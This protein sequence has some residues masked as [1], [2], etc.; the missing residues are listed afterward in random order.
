MPTRLINK[1]LTAVSSAFITATVLLV[2]MEANAAPM[3]KAE[4][5]LA[6]Q[7]SLKAAA[8]VHVP[9][10]RGKQQTHDSHV[11]ALPL[12]AVAN[13]QR[14]F[15]SST[16]EA[17]RKAGKPALINDAQQQ[18][19][20]GLNA[21]TQG[22]G[23]VRAH[24]DARNGT[25]AFLKPQGR[26]IANNA[27]MLSIDSPA[28]ADVAQR[29][30]ADQ[31]GLLR[32]DDPQTE[33]R[34]IK[35]QNEAD[36]RSHVRM[37][38]VYQGI[39]LWGKELLVHMGN[40]KGVYLV[41]GS[42]EPTPRSLDTSP[43][44]S[45]ETAVAAV[46]KDL[47]VGVDIPASA[48]LVIYTSNDG[49]S[50]LTYKINITP[51]ID[52]RWVYFINAHDGA[53]VHRI[54]NIPSG[55]V[56]A[57]GVDLLGV[58][59]TFNAWAQATGSYYLIDPGTPTV[60]SSYD[61]VL[62][63]PNLTGDTFIYS[64]N[65]GDGKSLYYNTS[66]FQ[67]SGW[68][69][70]AVSAAYNTRKV[71]DYYKTT[72]G[73]NSIDGNGM[74]LLIVTHQN[75]DSQGQSNIDNAFWNGQSMIYGDGDNQQFISFAGCLDVAAHEMSH[76]VIERTANLTYENQSGALNES[77]ADFFGAMVDRDDW[78]IGEDCTLGSP[79]YL[80]NMANPAL[81][82]FG[83][84]P[85]KMSQYNNLP[86]TSQGDHGGVHT[87]SGIPNRAA[88]LLADGLTVE[89]LG[90]SIGR[91][92]VEQIYYR[93]LE[94]YLTA[95]A[96]FVDAR[97]ALIQAA[98][99]LYGVN[100]NEA[101]AVALAWDTVEVTDNAGGSYTTP[102]PT[103]TDPV[104]GADIMV[105]LYASDGHYDDRTE[106]FKLYKQ[107]MDDPFSG[108]DS[109][110]DL[111]PLNSVDA[112]YTR[113]AVY[114]DI[115]GTWIFYVG[116]DNNLYVIDPT[117]TTDASYPYGK[118]LELT[119]SGDIYSIAV[120]P[121]GRYLAYT[122]TSADDNSIY[123]IDFNSATFTPTAYPVTPPSYQQGGSGADTIFY[124]DSL[125]FDYTGN[126]IVFDALNCVSTPTDACNVSGGGYQYWSVGEMNVKTGQ[127][128]LPFASQNPIIDIGYPSFAANNNSIIA[129]DY[130][131]WTDIANGNIA[132]SSITVDLETQKTKT[133]HNFGISSDVHWGVPSFWGDDHYLT[134]QAADNS[135]GSRVDRVAL[136]SS[137]AATGATATLNQYAAVMGVMHRAGERN[138][139]GALSPSST[140]LDFG[141][142][143]VGSSKTLGLTLTN[144]GNSD[145][146]I[147][148]ISLAGSAFVDDAINTRVVRGASLSFNVS[149]A[150]NS[151]GGTQTGTLTITS[152]GN[153]E[154][155]AVS[156][157]GA[158]PSQVQPTPTPEPDPTPT[159]AAGGGG[160]ILD[161]FTLLALVYAPLFAGRGRK[162]R[163]IWPSA[164]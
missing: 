95:S 111:G 155:V 22:N 70:A 24:F 150:P 43:A 126:T 118:N 13:L 87:N 156:L 140:L 39:P 99:D 103:P 141:E 31:R 92:K 112:S 151:N 136:D 9:L 38:Q 48:E 159:A 130:I 25:L 147:S 133:V 49:V 163:S 132:S 50:M 46:R 14:I 125:A 127:L 69:P 86:N 75:K 139:T 28:P 18:A 17:I 34:I 4:G 84:Q 33:T 131:D 97:R 71:Y 85:T 7:E 113:P 104:S 41:Q 145:V 157:V 67:L 68:D 37:Q 94:L 19:L 117:N 98:K 5:V 105:Y 124:A 2:C 26:T 74:N 82:A 76:G 36:G 123:I 142:V 54:N 96:Q 162:N 91:S 128:L 93:A 83:G 122:S 65:S 134:F 1:V 51:A 15:H 158:T 148:D 16:K 32:L 10:R 164:G 62:N 72:F 12:S 59:R 160:G 120:S 109:L 107:I 6:F 21:A 66:T 40:D 146:N 116:V 35:Q 135:A 153:P 44:I 102:A 100:S 23:G 53:I 64:A 119:F 3:F 106:P 90:T 29:F 143:A 73:R 129:L 77:F 161:P 79:G 121:D 110:K 42:Y 137:W 108:Y 101:Q 8:I 52:Q 11:A 60:D 152:D 89:G 63:G 20:R 56:A 78:Q 80:R 154:T 55:I 88:Y 114:T 58:S 57:S 27:H 138:L 30:L 144:N 47:N 61:P 45:K 115:L 81:S 149:F